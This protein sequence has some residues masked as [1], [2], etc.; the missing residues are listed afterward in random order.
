MKTETQCQNRHTHLKRLLGAQF[1]ILFFKMFR[2][3]KY[4]VVFCNLVNILDFWALFDLPS[5]R[6]AAEQRGFRPRLDN[7]CVPVGSWRLWHA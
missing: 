4:F 5:H 7:S 1:E 6:P 2:N 3:V